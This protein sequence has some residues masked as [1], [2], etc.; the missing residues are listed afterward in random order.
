MDILPGVASQ[1]K[2]DLAKRIWLRCTNKSIF[3]AE[4]PV[5]RSPTTSPLAVLEEALASIGRGKTGAR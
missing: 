3:L 1:R 2:Q 5:I 4:P